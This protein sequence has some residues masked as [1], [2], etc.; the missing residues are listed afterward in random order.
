MK[1][2]PRKSLWKRNLRRV[3]N[4]K[5]SVDDA[6]VANH[7]KVR[8]Q[9]HTWFVSEPPLSFVLCCTPPR[10]QD[11]S[12]PKQIS[13]SKAKEQSVAGVMGVAEEKKEEPS[14]AEPTAAEEV[15]KT[16]KTVVETATKIDKT[17]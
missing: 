15:E 1:T 11:G 2:Y 7:N 4:N 13:D 9:F 10:Q 6:D 5:R 14:S 3:G 8:T 17:T 12:P 16:T